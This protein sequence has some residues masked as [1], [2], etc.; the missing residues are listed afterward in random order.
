MTVKAQVKEL[1]DTSKAKVTDGVKTLEGYWEKTVAPFKEKSI[2]ELLDQ[3]GGLKPAEVVEKLKGSDLGK[4]WN[5]VKHEV[6]TAMGVAET[7]AVDKLTKEIEKLNTQIEALQKVKTDLTV[8]K[9]EL[10]KVKKAQAK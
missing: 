2:H 1:F 5:V 7:T 10:T 8:L 6:L 4:H 3:F 9:R